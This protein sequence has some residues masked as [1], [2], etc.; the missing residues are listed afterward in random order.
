MRRAS[1]FAD[2][3]RSSCTDGKKRREKTSTKQLGGVDYEDLFLLMRVG[4]TVT[5]PMRK[6]VAI[7]C[8]S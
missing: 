2:N 7:D 4:V 5:R 3:M 8:I 6:R 1:L